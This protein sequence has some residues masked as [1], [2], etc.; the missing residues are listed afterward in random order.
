[1]SP[2]KTTNFNLAW[3]SACHGSA[4]YSTSIWVQSFPTCGDGISGIEDGQQCFLSIA[5]VARGIELAVVRATE[6][7]PDG[8]R[9]PPQ[10]P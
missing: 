10:S 1:M 2:I 3:K 5:C 7:P 6:L 4:R 9:L 8:T